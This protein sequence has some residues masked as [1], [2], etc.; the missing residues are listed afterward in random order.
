MIRYESLPI[1]KLKKFVEYSKVKF[2]RNTWYK[3]MKIT[4]D[5]KELRFA[6]CIV[7][8]AAGIAWGLC[9]WCAKQPSTI[10]NSYT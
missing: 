1:D 6:L 8:S 10:N 5:D 2:K 9:Y 7:G 4:R 3:Q